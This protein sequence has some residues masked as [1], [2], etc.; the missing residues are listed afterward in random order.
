MGRRLEGPSGAG[1]RRGQ[2]RTII[3]TEA[4]PPPPDARHR[5]HLPFRVCARFVPTRRWGT[6]ADVHGCDV[7]VRRTGHLLSTG[8]VV[9]SEPQNALVVA[10][11][12]RRRR[13]TVCVYRIV[14]HRQPPST[15]GSRDERSGHAPAA[16]LCTVQIQFISSSLC[17]YFVCRA[18]QMPPEFW[19]RFRGDNCGITE[20]V[21]HPSG[22]C[23]LSHFADTG[24]VLSWGAWMW[25]CG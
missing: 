8:L 22:R 11:G 10:A 9:F 4:P 23:S 15:A 3:S 2:G 20:I 6:G 25:A 19:L 18:L 16:A 1:R 24:R 12:V 7:W 13:P 5:G 14:P 21:V 17:R